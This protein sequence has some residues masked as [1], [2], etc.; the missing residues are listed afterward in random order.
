MTPARTIEAPA[1]HG[2]SRTFQIDF[3][4]PVAAVHQA[5]SPGRAANQ[6]SACIR[7]AKQYACVWTT[8]FGSLVVPDV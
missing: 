5:R 6:R 2:P 7:F 8:P 4:Q 1:L 3:A